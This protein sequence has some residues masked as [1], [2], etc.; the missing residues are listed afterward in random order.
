MS[1]RPLL[2]IKALRVR[3]GEQTILH[4]ISLNVPLGGI[5]TVLCSN[6]VGKTTDAH[7]FRH[8]PECLRQHRL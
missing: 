1:D 6:G 3:M 2:D 8:L 4:D 5:V 7:A